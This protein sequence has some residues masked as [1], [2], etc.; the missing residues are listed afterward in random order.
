MFL[1]PNF[2]TEEA[3]ARG[4]R[5]HLLEV[6]AREYPDRMGRVASAAPAFLAA[7]EATYTGAATSFSG[8]TLNLALDGYHGDDS[9]WPCGHHSE[10][11]LALARPT[12]LRLYQELEEWAEGLAL[13]SV[14]SVDNEPPRWRPYGW[15]IA[16][17]RRLALGMYYEQEKGLEALCA[18]NRRS[19]WP[20]G[21][22][23]VLS[24]RPEVPV[25]ERW[26]Y[27]T[28]REYWERAKANLARYM[29]EEK[30]WQQ[31]HGFTL[32]LRRP[33]L[34]THLCW[35]AW[36]L[37]EKLS[38]AKIAQR[39]DGRSGKNLDFQA[40]QNALREL[41]PR[42]GITFKDRAATST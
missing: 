42:I 16:H 30:A 21:F 26:F 35:F 38:Y 10:E 40:V 9:E 32:P 15:A 18:Y 3:R 12:W 1:Q 19:V 23:E 7:Q 22:F 41:E 39:E 27:G 14:R 20:D 28:E 2:T 37:V 24:D 36:R 8:Y 5:W 31:Q 6:M 13:G 11:W 25:L 29:E 34:E 4:L 33:K 17:G